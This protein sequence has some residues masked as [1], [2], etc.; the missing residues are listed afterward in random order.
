MKLTVARQ[1]FVQH[2][3]VFSVNAI[4]DRQTDR[5][6]DGQKW[7]AHRAVS[8]AASRTRKIFYKALTADLGDSHAKRTQNSLMSHL[9]VF[10]ANYRPLF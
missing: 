2:H 9:A 10:R 4:Q 1:F 8:P 7:S 5:L 6:T 3:I